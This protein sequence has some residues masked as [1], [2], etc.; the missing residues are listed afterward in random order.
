MLRAVDYQ[1]RQSLLAWI[2]LGPDEILYLEGAE[3][4]DRVG[5]S[6][7]E[8]VQV[9]DTTRH[10]SLKTQKLLDAIKN[11]WRL[12]NEHIGVPVRLRFLSR[13][14]PTIER[15]EPFG[16][17]VAGLEL[18]QRRCLNDEGLRLL[19][20]FLDLQPSL[21]DSLK[22][23]LRNAPPDQLREGFF[24]RIA[25][26]LGSPD[27]TALD[28]VI[29]DKLA[30]LGE[31]LGLSYSEAAKTRHRFFA[32][33]FEIAGQRQGPRALTRTDLSKL[34]EEEALVQIPRAELA[35]LRRR[36]VQRG[37]GHTHVAPTP[38]D[39]LTGVPPLPD[40]IETR[41]SLVTQLHDHL[42]TW[43][44]LVLVGSSGM[45]KT[46]LTKLIA[47][48]QAP[49]HWRWVSLAN[50]RPDEIA[51]A[52]RNINA[53]LDR[54]RAIRALVL[55]DLDLRP[56]VVKS[57]EDTLIGLVC[58][59]RHARGRLLISSQ[60]ESLAKHA[61]DGWLP[62]SN[63]FRIPS[64][65]SSEL[66]SMARH[67]GCPD[68]ARLKTW[69]DLVR[70]R[71]RGH[72][73]L[74]RAVFVALRDKG[75][76]AL[77]EQTLTGLPEQMEGHRADAR[78]LLTLLPEPDR[79]LAYR[80][81][82][83]TRPFRR[84]HVLHIGAEPPGITAPGTSFDRLR[85]AWI[86]PL[87]GGYFR[88]SPLLEDAADQDY[89]APRVRDFHLAV[90]KAM[91]DCEP[92]THIEAGTAFRHAWAAREEEAIDGLM[93]N[94]M[95]QDRQDFIGIATQLIW[96]L[97][98][99]PTGEVLYPDHLSLSTGLRFLQAKV[100]LRTAPDLATGVFDAW[101]EEVF[102]LDPEP[103]LPNKYLLATHAL[104]Y[105]QADVPVER[106][107]EYFRIM[108]EAQRTL[109]G[110]DSFT[111]P[112]MHRLDANLLADVTD[113]IAHLGIFL[114]PRCENAARLDEII[115]AL[116]HLDEPL[117]ERILAALRRLPVET[118]AL[119]EKAWVHEDD[120]Q[121]PNW[122][123]CLQVLQHVAECGQRWLWPE[124]TAAA[125]RSRAMIYDENLH[126]PSAA[127]AE[128]D[129]A[130]REY[131]L[132]PPILAAQR[133]SVLFHTGRHAEALAGWE[134]AFAH[135]PA[136]VEPHDCYTA[137][138]AR[139]AG[140]AAAQIGDWQRSADWF[141][142]GQA[143]MLPGCDR[144]LDAGL[145]TDAGFSYWRANRPADC[146]KA[147]A[148]AWVVVDKLP[149][150]KTNLRAFRAR[151][152]LG[153][154]LLWIRNELY[155]REH[156][157]PRTEPQPG[158]ASYPETQEF[159]RDEPEG[160][161][162]VLPM[163]LIGIAVRLG[164][165][166]GLLEWLSPRAQRAASSAVRTMFRQTLVHRAMRR[167]EVEELP[168][169]ESELRAEAFLAYD[170]Q[171]SREP[172]VPLPPR[173][174][175]ESFPL[176]AREIGAGI[177]LAAMISLAGAG[178]PCLKYLPTWQ[179]A[180][181]AL[182]HDQGLSAWLA[183]LD[184]RFACTPE[185]S[186]RVL[187]TS[188]VGWERNLTA[189]LHLAAS[190]GTAPS[191]LLGAHAILFDDLAHSLWRRDIEQGFFSL[192]AQ[193][194]RRAARNRWAFRYP[195]Q[196]PA[197]LAEC[198]R[199]NAGLISAARLLNAALRAVDAPVGAEMRALIERYAA[200]GA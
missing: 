128:L 20:A 29:Q 67:L 59:L 87:G 162:E 191:Q 65:S 68:D 43:G 134:L 6:G 13:A 30:I 31:P 166:A 108:E 144:P 154:V 158:F 136:P 159:W 126:D 12:Y 90:A 175:F 46:T 93:R 176:D 3:D 9:Y 163:L 133:A 70:L 131:S 123:H 152:A 174:M 125:V 113:L 1:L 193:G 77:S 109:P 17:G 40:T 5:T 62:V 99:A 173:A 51:F 86:D 189:A 61:S 8:A 72:P 115:T 2:T 102:R 139:L 169:L 114:V 80:L 188:G 135:C 89:P 52:L 58:R 177:F 76:P 143:S 35:A 121:Q 44:Q 182:P 130:E 170:R 82:V 103:S 186:A 116:D 155:E 112:G 124:L 27:A 167:C 57:F 39:L 107:F 148:D 180:A 84:D 92:R 132:P 164:Q 45:G 190:P 21:P 122:P 75:W 101:H 24:N 88:L 171:V 153:H 147:L 49:D 118:R 165:D 25:W 160:D 119:V 73:L 198:D 200:E 55:D 183:E 32:E 197:I 50:R 100:A 28:V 41:D 4:F 26:D 83:T 185:Q 168:R 172:A 33:I 199:G 53:L 18:W 146:V 71:T 179:N 149:S 156:E 16:A 129:R 194:W 94:F 36:D 178:Q 96:F 23:F 22:A 74:A 79:E 54:D 63:S 47:N 97:A 161:P 37:H 56:E 60:K 157:D 184:Q 117:R 106:L 196:V 48:S 10:V 15:G 98:E 181:R 111:V 145:L 127:L 142:H 140:M 151:K 11:Y 81:S 195:Q 64:L 137:L 14:R 42:E 7:A 105:Y 85:G 34:L 192:V 120:S 95:E 104:A 141:R 150:G 38:D 78:Q 187:K 138:F 19:T 91:C 66:T 69:T 110:F